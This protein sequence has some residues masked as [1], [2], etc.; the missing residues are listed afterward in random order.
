MRSTINNEPAGNK[1]VEF[2]QHRASR[3]AIAAASW[4]AA[5]RRPFASPGR[6][7]RCRAA[8]RAVD[9]RA[10]PHWVFQRRPRRKR[11]GRPLRAAAAGTARAMGAAAGASS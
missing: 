7:R 9:R 10:R 2:I 6:P 1:I 8:G 3:A 4:R 5:T 11:E